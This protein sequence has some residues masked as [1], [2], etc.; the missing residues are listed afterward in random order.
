M[1]FDWSQYLVLAKQLSS[2]TDD[3]SLRSAVSRSYYC[4]FNLA[5]ERAERNGYRRTQDNL[6]GDHEKLWALYARNSTSQECSELALLGPRMKQRR[7]RADYRANFDRLA[8][9]VKDAIEDAE[10]CVNLLSSLPS[11]MPIDAPRTW[12][13]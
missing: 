6:G 11:N 3:A 12:S 9:G 10:K 8:D 7:V 13:F 2:A 5:V 1:G 4:A